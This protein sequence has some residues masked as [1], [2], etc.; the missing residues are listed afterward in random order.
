MEGSTQKC[1]HAGCWLDSLL[2]CPLVFEYE[3][4]RR[5]G[6]VEYGKHHP[7]IGCLLLFSEIYNSL[8]SGPLHDLT[9]PS[10]FPKDQVL[11]CYQVGM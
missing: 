7:G 8:G 1:Q 5:E 10:H 9:Q 11:K 6:K 2:A 3:G 4:G